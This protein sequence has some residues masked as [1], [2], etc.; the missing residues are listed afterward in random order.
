MDSFSVKSPGSKY[1]SIYVA[2][3]AFFHVQEVELRILS[4]YEPQTLEIAL[5]T[6]QYERNDQQTYTGNK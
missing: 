1:E 6:I 3:K 2:Q 4:N 5:K